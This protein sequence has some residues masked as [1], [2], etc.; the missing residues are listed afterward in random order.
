L[1]SQ[2]NPFAVVVLAH[3]KTLELSHDDEARR[4]SEVRLVKGLYER[5]FSAEQIRQLYRLIE[6]MMDLPKPLAALA[7]RE[8]H[9]FAK[10]KSMPFVTGAEI[11]GREKGLAEGRAEGLAKGREEGRGEGLL[12]GIRVALEIKF[13]VRGLAL[14]PEIQ[15]IQDARLLQKILDAITEADTPEAVRRVW[16]NA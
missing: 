11:V 8:I 2:A 13:A 9:D 14:I 4:V 1:E 10:E 7:W 6:G 15:E 3:L 16:S 5:G 12:A